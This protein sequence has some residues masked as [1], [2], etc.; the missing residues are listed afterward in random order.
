MKVINIKEVSIDSSFIYDVSRYE[1]SGMY[2]VNNNELIYC[3]KNTSICVFICF[4]NEIIIENIEN[5]EN[6]KETNMIT[7][8]LLLKTLAIALNKEEYKNL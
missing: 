6:A 1:S 5:K 8:E 3:N 7:D 4:Q 2:I